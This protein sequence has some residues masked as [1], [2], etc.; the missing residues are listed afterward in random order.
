MLARRPLGV[1]L[2]RAIVDA[3]ATAAHLLDDVP[4]VLNEDSRIVLRLFR[5]V[6][7]R[8]GT[9]DGCLELCWIGLHPIARAERPVALAPK[10]LARIDQREVDVEENGAGHPITQFPDFPIPQ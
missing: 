1:D 10:H 6:E 2:A 3:R 7:E 8:G 9:R 5:A 4:R